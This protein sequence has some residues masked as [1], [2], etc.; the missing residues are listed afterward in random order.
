MAIDKRPQ[1]SV[2][3]GDRRLPLEVRINPRATRLILR[4]HRGER[5]QVTCPSERHVH[6]AVA[7]AQA[8]ADW[9]ADQLQA[10]PAPKPY[11]PGGCIPV[12]GQDR[13]IVWHPD[14]VAAAQLSDDAVTT[15]GANEA[16]VARRIE[17]LLRQVC[18]SACEAGATRFAT[19]LGVSIGKVSVRE[20][21][22][23]WGSCSYTG[24]MS[25]NWRLVH[26][27]L[28][29]LRYVVA[30]E[31]AHREHMNHS[32]AFWRVVDA[33]DP[34]YRSAAKW[35]QERGAELHAFGRATRSSG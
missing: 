13:M 6:Q 33:L 3:V 21:H 31:V 8:R 14:S 15:G 22:S 26:A 2:V 1:G 35:L 4:L 18:Q 20:M 28:P 17:R 25:F 32:P 27:P 24:D 7:L 29:V 16:A 19:K 9:L 11:I 23:R 12:L 5:V 30:H 34:D 10:V